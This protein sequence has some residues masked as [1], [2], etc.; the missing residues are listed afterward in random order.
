MYRRF[1]GVVALAMGLTW[2]VVAACMLFGLQ[3]DPGVQLCAVISAGCGMLGLGV[4]I[5]LEKR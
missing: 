4:H 2:F 5:C 1:S 3:L